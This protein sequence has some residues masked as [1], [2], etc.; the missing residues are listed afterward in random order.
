MQAFV[1]ALPDH[2][3]FHVILYDGCL[4]ANGSSMAGPDDEEEGK[5]KAWRHQYRGERERRAFFEAQH[6]IQRLPLPKDQAGTHPLF[7]SCRWQYR[8]GR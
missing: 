4:R 8:V 3:R 6:H 1:D 2:T 5:D 7:P